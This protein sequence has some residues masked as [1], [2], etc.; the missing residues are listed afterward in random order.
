MRWH[1]RKIQRDR[2][3]GMVFD[4]R[5]KHGSWGRFLFAAMVSLAFWGGVLAFVEVRETLDPRLTDDEV[6]LTLVDLNLPTNRW[7]SDLMERETYLHH[8]WDVAQSKFV[9]D[10]IHEITSKT[11]HRIY[12]PS[13]QPTGI[14]LPLINLQTLPGI[15]A[16]ILPPRDEVR[17]EPYE[18]PPMEWR[19][20]VRMIDGPTTIPDFSTRWTSDG[21]VTAGES[22]IVTVA[23][24]PQGRVLVCESWEN[25]ADPRTAEILSL[26]QNQTWPRREGDSHLA[27]WR[28]E[29]IIVSRPARQ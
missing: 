7:L 4:W 12:R 19:F 9:D 18:I 16:G 1:L 5:M 22:W 14:P 10:W 2:A 28:L 13:I 24:D 11:P 3:A 23:V 27:W 21:L 29:A 6:D 15:G 25:E 8:R 26:C 20:E 17:P